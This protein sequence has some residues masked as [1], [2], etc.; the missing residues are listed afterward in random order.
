MEDEK[1]TLVF[2]YNSDSGLFNL[3]FDAAHKIFSPQ[4]YSCNLCAIT[5]GNF[6]MKNEWREYLKTLSIPFE[7][8]HANEFKEKYRIENAQKLPA[9]FKREKGELK[10]VIDAATINICR[11]VNDLKQIINAQINGN[12]E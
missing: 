2:V 3:A 7:F 5:H 4:T 11:T 6:G 8:L 10:P 1:P 12:F 9:V